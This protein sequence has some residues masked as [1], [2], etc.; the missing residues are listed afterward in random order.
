MA[1]E[2]DSLVRRLGD[3]VDLRQQ[4]LQPPDP[5]KCPY[6]HTFA[7]YGSGVQLD[8]VV[9]PA[10]ARRQPSADWVVLYDPDARIQGDALQTLVDAD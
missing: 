6:Q 5:T 7:W 4:I 2:I 8:L 10:P 9:S 1:P 3:I